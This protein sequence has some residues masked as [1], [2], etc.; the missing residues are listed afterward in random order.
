MLLVAVPVKPGTLI[1]VGAVG[2]TYQIVEHPELVVRAGSNTIPLRS[3]FERITVKEIES[4][5]TAPVRLDRLS[6]VSRDL[7]GTR[8]KKE[9]RRSHRSVDR[10]P[11]RPALVPLV[12]VGLAWLLFGTP[13][14]ANPAGE[15][16][17]AHSAYVAQRYDEAE[18]RLRALLD[19]ATGALKDP[20]NVADARMYLGAVLVAE[21]HRE[22]A[23][24]VFEQLLREQPEYS[25]DPLLVKQDAID[26]FIDVRARL[27]DL[28]AQR[29]EENVNQ[30]NIEKARQAAEQQRAAMRV[31]MLEQLASEQ[32]VIERHSRWVALIPFGVGQF[33]NGQIGLGATFFVAEG[34]LAA[35]SVVATGVALYNEGQVA[36]A[37][38]RNDDTQFQYEDRARSAA[39]VSVALGGGFVLAAAMGALHAELSFVPQKIEIHQRAIPPLS[40]APIVGPGGVGIAGTF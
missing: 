2:G 31:A 27:R 14:A 29:I 9:L 21:G 17:K 32:I 6:A 22:E 5:A 19:P 23:E 7:A 4:G 8:T 30:A 25:E 39:W 40:L 34:L 28:L 1:V 15:L 20:G 26:V 12:S 3:T 37:Y 24:K 13:A 38:R 36:A 18:A 33:Q 11:V 35:G 10:W 16:Q